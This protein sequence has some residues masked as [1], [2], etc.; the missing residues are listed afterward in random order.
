MVKKAIVGNAEGRAITESHIIKSV[1]DDNIVLPLSVSEFKV[2]MIRHLK[3][4]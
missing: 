4:L 2:E 1:A 3:L